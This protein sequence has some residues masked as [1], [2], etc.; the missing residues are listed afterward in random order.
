MVM[1]KLLTI[2]MLLLG[3]MAA[4]AQG[5]WTTSQYAADELTGQAAY[6]AYNYTEPGKGSYISWGWDDPDFR[7][8]TERGIFEESVCY[9]WYGQYRAVRV[10]VGIYNTQGVLLEKFYIEMYR[11][12]SSP[13]DKIHLSSMK[14]ERKKAKKIAK[15]LSKD[16]GIVRFVCARYSQSDFEIMVPYYQ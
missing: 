15:A 2:V 3:E 10:L 8:I 9:A 4:S 6:T 12:R 1:K 16:K 14:K 5:K 7:L 13:G 11:E